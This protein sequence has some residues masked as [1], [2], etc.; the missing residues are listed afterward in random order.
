MTK[1][2]VMVSGN[3]TTLQ[4]I[5]DAVKNKKIDVEI[6][7]VIAD[8]EC[9]A[10]KRAED[11]NIPY[12]ILKRGEYFQRDLKEEMRSSKCDFFVLAGF[13]SIIG[14]EITD[15]FRYRIIN[16]HPSLLPCFGGHG[17]YGRKVHEAV[18]KSGMKYSGC[19][20]HF[21]TDEVD[22]GP[23][24]LQRCVS[25]EDVDDAQSLE[26]KIHGIE[27]SAIVEAISL[28][29]NGHYKIEGKRVILNM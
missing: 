10:I 6:S 8:R 15:E 11:N 27:H 26:E 28:L 4:A 5:I 29:S 17:F 12:R 1:I 18:I 23:I 9:L 25:V 24:I 19:T 14:K 22:G 2:C 3:G 16:T 21:V 7:K 13:L 20:V